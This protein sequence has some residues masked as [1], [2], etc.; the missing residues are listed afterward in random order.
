MKTILKLEEAAL[1]VLGIGL[2]SQL[3][4]AWWWF[5]VL[6]LLPDIGMLGYLINTRVGA[7]TYNLFHY[8]AIAVGLLIFGYIYGYE[9]LLL[10]G[11]MLFSHIAF[12]R[13]LGYG[14]KYPDNFKN[15]HL[16]QIGKN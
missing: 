6:L 7:F 8:R 16:G 3:D 10:I 9:L 11:V 13:M 14:L 4:F 12:D 5:L 2:F 1:F 15:T